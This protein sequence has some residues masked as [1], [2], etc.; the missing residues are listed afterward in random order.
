VSLN[1]TLNTKVNNISNAMTKINTTLNNISST[2][3]DAIIPSVSILFENFSVLSVCFK[4]FKT[5]ANID[6]SL[7]V[8][9]NLT[10][11][12]ASVLSNLSCSKLFAN[13]ASFV[14]FV[15]VGYSDDRLKQR[16]G[17]MTDCCTRIKNIKPFV[18]RPKI[19]ACQRYGIVDEIRYGISAQDVFA[20]FPYAVKKTLYSDYL[21]IDYSSL[22]PIIIGCLNEL[23]NKTE[24]LNP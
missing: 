17:N 3:K 21:T 19:T 20:E 1:Y 2:V 15:S 6:D 7:I 22:I 16:I 23:I 11:Q 24:Y 13:D 18:Y 14:N 10:C 12:N 9:K 4:T 5:N 8:N